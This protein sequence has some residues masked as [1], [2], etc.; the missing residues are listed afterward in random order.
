VP[1]DAM[2]LI[3]GD[4]STDTD[5]RGKGVTADTVFAQLK[6]AVEN[7]KPATAATFGDSSARLY[8][9]KGIYADHTYSVMG[10]AER[11]GVKYVKL[12]NPWGESEPRGNG[13]DDGIFVMKMDEFMKLYSGISVNG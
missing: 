12:R 1:G 9:G 7:H 6:D 8:K 4:S 5:L 10:V 3:T 2:R 13:R 11:D